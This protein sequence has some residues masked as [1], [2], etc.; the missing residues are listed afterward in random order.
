LGRLILVCVGCGLGLL[1]GLVLLGGLGALDRLGGALVGVLSRLRF[2]AACVGGRLTTNRR[3]GCG[4]DSA[5]MN[6]RKQRL[7]ATGEGSGCR[8]EA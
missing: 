3:E 6:R 5:D 8:H 7:C 1:G 2:G 4:R